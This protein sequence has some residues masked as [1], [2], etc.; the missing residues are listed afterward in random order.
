MVQTLGDPW[1]N[2]PATEN[3]TSLIKRKTF[4]CKWNTSWSSSSRSN[5][6][7][8]YHFIF[9]IIAPTVLGGSCFSCWL[10]IWWYSLTTIL[11]S[12]HCRLSTLWVTLLW[13][14]TCWTESMHIESTL[15]CRS[16]WVLVGNR[17]Q[18]G[19]GPRPEFDLFFMFVCLFLFWIIDSKLDF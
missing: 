19:N 11:V 13:L 3:N 18:A 14:M 16:C 6:T 9:K 8:N 15:V 17:M 5:W 2:R 7:K 10:L 1:L 4:I 12:W